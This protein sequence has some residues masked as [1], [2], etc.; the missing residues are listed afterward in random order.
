MVNIFGLGLCLCIGLN[1]IDK[2]MIEKEDSHVPDRF[3]N[4]PCQMFFL[5]YSL[6]SLDGAIH[7]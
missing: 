7:F 6:S 5:Q 2:G 1:N 4:W 3:K